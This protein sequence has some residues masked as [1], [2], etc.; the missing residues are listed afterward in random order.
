MQ[1][2]FQQVNYVWNTPARKN[3]L[4]IS[5]CQHS[6]FGHCSLNYLHMTNILLYNVYKGTQE[7][8]PTLLHPYHFQ[9]ALDF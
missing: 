3:S 2:K 4:Y 7:N 8:A 6:Y 5:S 1:Y 9:Q